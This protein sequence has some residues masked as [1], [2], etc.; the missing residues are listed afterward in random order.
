[1]SSETRLDIARRAAAGAG[2]AP[3]CGGDALL[4][5]LYLVP[6]LRQA[7]AALDSLRTLPCAARD[8]ASLAVATTRQPLH[9]SLRAGH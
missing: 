1:M 7:L 3:G 9:G 2:G 8:I 4:D 6:A 5:V